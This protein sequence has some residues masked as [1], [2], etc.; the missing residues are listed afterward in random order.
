MALTLLLTLLCI[1]G[2]FLMLFAAVAF[3]QDRR[4]F[5][6]APRDVQEKVQNHE[7]RFP[8][9]HILGYVL[10]T[11][12]IAIII[13]SVIIAV[14]DGIQREYGFLQFF[15]R[16]MIMLEGYKIWDMLFLDYYL[17]TKSKFYQHYYPEVEGCESMKKYGFNLKQQ[18]LKLLLIFPI[19][20]LAIAG[21]C[22]LIG[23]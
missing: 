6:T 21:L 14:W 8:G 11:A 7:E 4:F 13:S 23:N 5:G 19:A 18:L 15:I 16:F 1:V 2:V 20:S 17:L 12:A 9:M 22:V 10:C 3:V